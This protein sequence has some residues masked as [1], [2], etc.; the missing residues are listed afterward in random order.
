MLFLIVSSLVLVIIGF[1]LYFRKSNRKLHIILMSS[2]FLIDLTLVLVIEFQ[3]HAIETVISQTSAFVWFHA[4]ISLL[5]LVSYV[6]LAVLGTKMAKL[7]TGTQFMS[8]S[9]QH[10]NLA[11]VFIVLRLINYVT[12]FSMVN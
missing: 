4:T 9:N 11:K 2:A 3:R 6:A 10:L 8:I 1:G 12:S 7:N 5:V